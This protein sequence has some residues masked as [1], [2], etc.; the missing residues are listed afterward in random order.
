M[1]A[2]ETVVNFYS[3]ATGSVPPLLSVPSVL[4]VSWVLGRDYLHSRWGLVYLGWAVK[5]EKKEREKERGDIEVIIV[6]LGT[7]IMMINPCI[8]L[9][10]Y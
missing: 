1:V 7:S 8:I 10:G 9:V 3:S 4:A 5:N 2:V 6:S